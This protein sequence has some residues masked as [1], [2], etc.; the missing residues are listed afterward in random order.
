M[1]ARRAARRSGRFLIVAGA[2]ASAALGKR[3]D[4][5]PVG[6]AVADAEAH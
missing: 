6:K 3:Q 4:Q 5:R 1:I 2:G